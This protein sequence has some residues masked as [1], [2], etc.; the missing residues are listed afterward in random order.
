MKKSIFM[1]RKSSESLSP[2]AIG[3]EKK[4]QSDSKP[5]STD[6]QTQEPA[7]NNNTYTFTNTKQVTNQIIMNEIL[8]RK[9]ED[10]NIKAKSS[11]VSLYLKIKNRISFQY[12]RDQAW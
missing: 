3:L 10:Q 12:R 6:T 5:I 9:S 11:L 4:S 8:K 2:R 1:K 7:I